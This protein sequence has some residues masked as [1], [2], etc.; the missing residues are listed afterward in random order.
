LAGDPVDVEGRRE[1]HRARTFD[2]HVRASV[3]DGDLALEGK[4]PVGNEVHPATELQISRRLG[5]ID[6]DD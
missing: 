4:L 2:V 6:D 1:P 5:G 3:L